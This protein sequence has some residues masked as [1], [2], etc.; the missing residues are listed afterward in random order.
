MC[1]LSYALSSICVT[2]QP[3]RISNCLT[4]A[5]SISKSFSPA[6][7]VDIVIDITTNDRQRNIDIVF[8]YETPSKA[9]CL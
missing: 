1:A 3:V 4:V 2:P 7:E 5:V 8:L 6:A 9:L